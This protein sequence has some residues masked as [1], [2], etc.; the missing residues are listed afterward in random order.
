[1]SYKTILLSTSPTN[2]A[3]RHCLRTPWHWSPTTMRKA[4][5]IGPIYVHS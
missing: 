5:A 4:E 1:M 3:P 2:D